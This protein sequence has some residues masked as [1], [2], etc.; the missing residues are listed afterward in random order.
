LSIAGHFNLDIYIL[1]LTSVG[2]DILATL[3]LRL[4][5]HCIILL[6]DVDVA[7]QNRLTDKEADHSD[8]SASL[9]EKQGEGVTLSG[10]LNVLD[11]V[12]SQEG[13]LL[14]MTTNYIERLDAALIR[15]GRIDQKIEFWL[16]DV[17]IVNQLFRFL[18]LARSDFF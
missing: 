2:D 13:R 15:P 14:I 4:P 7:T 18:H 11:G 3:F 6:E 16:A 17:G 5:Q 1:N 10:L 8:S 12:G 9:T